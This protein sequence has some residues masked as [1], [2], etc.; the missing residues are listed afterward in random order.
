[1][2]A[3]NTGLK[4]FINGQ[5]IAT[6]LGFDLEPG[7]D[8]D[9]SDEPLCDGFDLQLGLDSDD[10]DPEGE[11][12]RDQCLAYDYLAGMRLD[13]KPATF[14]ATT[15]WSREDAE[16]F[17]STL[18][19]CLPKPE[20]RQRGLTIEV[21]SGSDIVVGLPDGRSV[22]AKLWSAVGTARS[23]HTH[24]RLRRFVRRGDRIVEV[25]AR[26]RSGSRSLQ[27]AMEEVDIRGCG[28]S[29]FSIEGTL[30]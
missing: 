26:G 1:M 24:K 22:T 11:P 25:R 29:S 28:G 16:A 18:D 30:K 6:A 5:P 19:K 8:Q 9:L 14:T 7:E 2:S 12:L 27:E 21:A 10:L 13:A 20:F 4:M 23:A 17:F 15:R 3:I